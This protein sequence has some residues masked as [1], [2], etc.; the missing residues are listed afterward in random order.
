MRGM[1]TCDCVHVDNK[2]IARLLNLVFLFKKLANEREASH[3][4]SPC[5]VYEE[6][7]TSISYVNEC[8][9][10]AYIRDILFA[11]SRAPVCLWK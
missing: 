10:L 7:K 9:L 3:F 11:R 5:S 6:I 4:F 2:P 8:L 1:N